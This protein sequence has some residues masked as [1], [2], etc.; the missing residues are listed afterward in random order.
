MAFAFHLVLIVMIT[1]II[2]MYIQFVKSIIVNI[3]IM[4][5]EAEVT[6]IAIKSMY[7]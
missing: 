2:L 6:T 7:H 3:I 4:A 1:K 5:T